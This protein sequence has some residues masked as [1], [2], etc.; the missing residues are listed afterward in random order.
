M[1]AIT[2]IYSPVNYKEHPA[3][4]TSLECQTISLTLILSCTPAKTG[5]T[6]AP[7]IN[8]QFQFPLSHASLTHRH[9]IARTLRPH[10]LYWS[11]AKSRGLCCAPM[12]LL[13]WLEQARLQ[14][15]GTS[16]KTNTTRLHLHY[17]MYKI[18]C[19]LCLGPFSADSL[20]SHMTRSV[21]VILQ[22]KISLTQ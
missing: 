7:A 3:T 19:N 6:L 15:F 21:H 13:L 2:Q 14:L 16:Q 17:S 5:S 1:A 11:G 10:S 18:C 22:D 12:G 4:L 8:C 20:L 9:S